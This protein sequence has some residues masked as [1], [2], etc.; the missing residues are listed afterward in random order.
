MVVGSDAASWS[1]VDI[2]DVDTS[3]LLAYL[4]EPTGT[5]FADELAP[6]AERCG[7]ADA[8]ILDVYT[9]RPRL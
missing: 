8:R 5:P 3:G 2:A 1:A 6:W 9:F 4:P 7:G